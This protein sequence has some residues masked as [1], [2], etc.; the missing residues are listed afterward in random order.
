MAAPLPLG[1]LVR[2]LC[3][4]VLLASLTTQRH[5]LP[6][7]LEAH[8]FCLQLTWKK[9]KLTLKDMHVPVKNC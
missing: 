2:Q 3:E 4:G 8:Y 7:H 6:P 5:H 1:L 9:K